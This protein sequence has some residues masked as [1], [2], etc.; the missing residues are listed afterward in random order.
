MKTSVE[1][2][3]EESERRKDMVALFPE[4]LEACKSALYSLTEGD[5]YNKSK[6]ITHLI[7]IIEKAEGK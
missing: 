6:I 2:L 7:E 1:Q 4:L 5:Q 3:F